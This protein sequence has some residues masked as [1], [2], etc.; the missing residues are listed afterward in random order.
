MSK[1]LFVSNISNRITTCVTASIVSAHSSDM[2][3]YQ[4]AN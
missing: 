4:T 3:F 2:D 1:M